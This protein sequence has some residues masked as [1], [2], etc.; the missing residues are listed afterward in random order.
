VRKAKEAKGMIDD[1]V[2]MRMEEGIQK[3]SLTIVIRKK[4]V[5]GG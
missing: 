1:D 4:K 3:E 5:V 2:G